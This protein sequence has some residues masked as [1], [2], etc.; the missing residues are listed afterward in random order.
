[1]ADEFIFGPLAADAR[2]CVR[3]NDG[4]RVRFGFANHWEGVARRNPVPEFIRTFFPVEQKRIAKRGGE[5][6]YF[7][8]ECGRVPGINL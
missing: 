1:M 4:D 6:G 7:R 8:Y 3:P 2:D 5:A